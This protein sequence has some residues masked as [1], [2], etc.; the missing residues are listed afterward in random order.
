M[1][2]AS[3]ILTLNGVLKHLKIEEDA[4]NLQKKDVNGESKVKVEDEFKVNFVNERES[5][6]FKR[7]EPNNTNSNDNKKKNR[8]CYNCSKK[9]H[10]KF[11]CQYDKKQKTSGAS[12]TNFVDEIS[13]IVAMMLLGILT[14]VNTTTPNFSKDWWY[15]SGVAIHVCNDKNQFKNYEIL[16]KHKV[17]MANGVRAKVHGK[18]CVNIQF[19]SGKKLVLT[20][21]LHVPDIIKNLVSTDI[22]NKKGLKAVLEANKVILFKNGVFVGKIYSCNDMF[23]LSIN[24][25]DDVSLCFVNFAYFSWYDRLGHVNHKMLQQCLKMV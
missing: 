15:D 9:D 4:R 19:T 12:T 7:K 8:N 17:V 2:H 22:L 10:Y 23:K 24:K 14:E 3:K 21:V 6:N 20:N 25:N 1:L 13:E 5:F 18:G 16:E 11:E